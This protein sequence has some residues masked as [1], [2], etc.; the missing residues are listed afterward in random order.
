MLARAAGRSVALARKY[1][2]AT[3]SVES[4]LGKL[5]STGPAKDLNRVLSFWTR[6]R[7]IAMLRRKA[8]LAGIGGIEVYGGYFPPVGQLAVRAPRAC[9]PALGIAARSRRPRTG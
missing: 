4:G 3:I 6:T 5:A 2:A 1:G 9:A 8:G 7:F